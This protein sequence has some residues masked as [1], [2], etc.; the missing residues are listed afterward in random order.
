MLG[1]EL[2]ETTVSRW[3]RRTSKSPTPAKRWLSLPISRELVLHM[4]TLDYSG[5]H[6]PG[7]KAVSGNTAERFLFVSCRRTPVLT[8]S[9][10]VKFAAF[11]VTYSSKVVPP[12]KSDG[13]IL[14][15]ERADARIVINVLDN[16][17]F[18]SP[19]RTCVQGQVSQ[20]AAA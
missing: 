8:Q 2:S 9:G 4:Y 6:R 10:S 13:M 5:V 19:N 14:A 1:F 11:F 17:R 7:T 16:C 20:D 3:M 12:F 18:Q 15:N